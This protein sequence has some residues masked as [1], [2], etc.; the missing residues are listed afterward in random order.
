MK[1]RYEEYREDIISM[2]KDGCG[3]REI[4]DTL[5]PIDSDIS[6][7]AFDNYIQ[8]NYL[9]RYKPVE[10]EACE[11]CRYYRDMK[12]PS[13]KESKIFYC[14]KYNHEIRPGVKRLKICGLKDAD[15]DKNELGLVKDWLRRLKNVKRKHGNKSDCVVA[16]IAGFDAYETDIDILIKALEH[17]KKGEK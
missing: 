14:A 15:V 6:F 4:F 13:S 8:R 9:H 11:E 1:S 7:E 10:N 3:R 16:E 2:M 5:V 17:Y 12:R